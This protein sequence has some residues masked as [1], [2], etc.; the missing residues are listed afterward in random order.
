MVRRY[1]HLVF[2]TME[3]RAALF[4]SERHEL[5]IGDSVAIRASKPAKF[6]SVPRAT[7]NRFNHLRTINFIILNLVYSE[8]FGKSPFTVRFKGN[9]P[10]ID[11]IYPRSVLANKLGLKPPVLTSLAI[12]VFWGQMII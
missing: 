7:C 6:N 2:R 9:E 4:I 3:S 12:L 5:I 8:R 11:H 10:H 1:S